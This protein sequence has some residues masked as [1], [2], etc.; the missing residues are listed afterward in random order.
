M[1]WATGGGTLTVNGQTLIGNPSGLTV[2][3][4]ALVGGNGTL[5][6]TIINAG[7]TLSPGNS[8]GTIT[9]QGNLTF[10]SGSSY[11]VE[12]SPVAA[13][14]T[15][16]T[17]TAAL[18]GNVLATLLP[19]TQYKNKYTILSSA[20]LGGTTFAA[21]T[22]SNV[23]PNFST[24]LSYTAT[25]VILNVSGVLPGGTVNERSVAAAINGFF[26]NGG[27]LPPGFVSIF[28]L[29]GANLGNALSQLPADRQ[30]VLYCKTGVRSAEALAI[31]LVYAAQLA[32]RMGRI[33]RARVDEHYE[34]VGGD[35][36]STRLNS[37]H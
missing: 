5:P 4:G 2:N 12:V 36:K 29:T 17:G 26:N 1:T 23:P 35:R 7:A 31:G 34:V 19:G 18:S 10:A 21:L 22:S 14:R 27:T 25:D 28:G 9:V 11:V 15:N 33:S 24:S 16:V 37:S 3:S 30:V 8:I 20:G 13:D 32:H 6:A